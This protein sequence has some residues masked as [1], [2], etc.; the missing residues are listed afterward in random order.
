MNADLKGALNQIDQSWKSFT[1]RNKRMTKIQVKK[2][3]EYG[4]KQGYKSTSEFSLSEIDVVLNSIPNNTHQM[5][6]QQ[7]SMKL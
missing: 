1:H 2:V 6:D 3:L 5:I 7:Y 4:L